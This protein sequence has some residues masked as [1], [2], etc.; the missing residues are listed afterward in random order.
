MANGSQFSRRE[1]L[2]RAGVVLTGQF[3]ARVKQSVR[4]SGKINKGKLFA[5][6]HRVFLD[7]QDLA[8][9]DYRI[10]GCYKIVCGSHQIIPNG[11]IISLTSSDPIM[12]NL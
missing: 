12:L 1:A 5:A 2:K 10:R 7:K 9:E 4:L 11:V 3:A 8:T 6:V